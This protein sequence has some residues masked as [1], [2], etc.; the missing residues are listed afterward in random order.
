MSFRYQGE[1]AANVE[2]Y[3]RNVLKYGENTNHISITMHL[4][5]GVCSGIFM[6][7]IHIFRGKCMAAISNHFIQ[8]CI[9]WPTVTLPGKRQKLTARVKYGIDMRRMYCISLFSGYFSKKLAMYAI[10]YEL[11]MWW[12]EIIL[13]VHDVC[14]LPTCNTLVNLRTIPYSRSINISPL[15]LVHYSQRSKPANVSFQVSE[16]VKERR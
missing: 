6:T 8:P 14:H 12:M 2:K 7:N 3:I 10:A 4:L 5:P 1:I 9:S 16:H 13:D 15:E 11:F